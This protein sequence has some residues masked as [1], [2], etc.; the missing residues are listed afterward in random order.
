LARGR[1]ETSK[2][3]EGATKRQRPSIPTG[4]KKLDRAILSTMQGQAWNKN[5]YA[6]NHELS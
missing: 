6:L 4:D 1:Q 5:K 3:E 2:R